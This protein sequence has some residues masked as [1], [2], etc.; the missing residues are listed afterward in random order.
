MQVL[1]FLPAAG[2]AD[3]GKALLTEN[4]NKTE[5]TGARKAAVVKNYGKLPLYFI[6]NK[7]QVD[8][9]VK[10]YERG[11]G[12]ATF[13]TNH[14]V[15]IGLTK[16]DVKAKKTSRHELI[17]KDLTSDKAARPLSEAVSL[18]FV[19]ANPKAKISADDKR[20]GRVNYFIGNDRSK[21]RTGIPTFGAVTYRDVYK[22]I[23]IKFYGNNRRLEH[24]IIVRP[25]G[26]FSLVKFAYK[27]AQGLKVTEDGGLEVAFKDG[28]IIEKKPVIYQEIG[29]RRVA[30]EGSYRLLGKK[31]GAF[32]YGFDVASYDH[33]KKLVI[34]P[35]LVYSTYWGGSFFDYGYSIDV[36]NSGSVYVAGNTASID[37]PLMSPLQSGI[38]GGYDCFVS[39]LN[40]SGTAIGVIV[41]CCV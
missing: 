37:F 18:S 31:D 26:D 10:F 9:A 19:G 29:G 41:K 36:D 8:N 1:V 40:P 4:H 38:R 30:V 12:H 23:D 3:G 22:N 25:G 17:S 21:W 16:R 7:G 28:K 20:T 24:D 33:S 35:V 27:G 14:G 15:V 5:V 32:E 39:K 13:F 6:E 11:A 34:D 2:F